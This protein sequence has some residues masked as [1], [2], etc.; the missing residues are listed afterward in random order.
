ML[1]IS[2]CGFQLRGYIQLPDELQPLQVQ[3]QS[4]AQSL[5]E[6]LNRQLQQSGVATT[7]SSSEARLQL[8]LTD[9][10][11]SERQVIFGVVEEYELE[12]SLQATA[13][14][15]EGNLL[16]SD[17]TFTTQRQYRYNSEEDTLLARDSLR[18]DLRRDMQDDLIRQLT[19]RIQALENRVKQP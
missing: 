6:R 5:G 15:R 16:L 19:L 10:Q 13:K 18:A 1:V 8:K 11:S 12:L 4:S 14:D 3:A 7:S 9:L 17:E 2:A